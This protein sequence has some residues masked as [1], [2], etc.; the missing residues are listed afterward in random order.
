MRLALLAMP[1]LALPAA[2]PSPAVAQPL[3][4]QVAKAMLAGASQPGTR[5]RTM[6]G[7]AGKETL[8][9]ES[10]TLPDAI[11]MREADNGRWLRAPFGAAKR[12]E[13]AEAALKALPLSDCSGP[14]DLVDGGK[15]VSTYDFTQPNPL[16]PGG[17]SRGTIWI[18]KA[19]GLPVRI[20]ISPTSYQTIEYGAFAAPK[21]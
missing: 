1:L 10:V 3:C 7:S 17:K 2:A 15:P 11:Y 5:Q 21:P 20:V 9:L 13:M 19:D 12:R 18:G 4:D 8:K 16:E 6:E 14:R